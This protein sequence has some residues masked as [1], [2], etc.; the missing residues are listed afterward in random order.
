VAGKPGETL[1]TVSI[2][3]GQSM[4]LLAADTKGEEGSLA[5]TGDRIAFVSQNR[6]H[7]M[8]ADGSEVK[9]LTPDMN[10]VLGV[11]TSRYEEHNPVWTHDGKRVV[12]ISNAPGNYEVLSVS[13]DGGDVQRLT[14]DA[15]VDRNVA[16]SPDLPRIA[17]ERMVSATDSDLVLALPDGSQQLQFK[18]QLPGSLVTYGE[19]KPKFLPGGT[20]LAYVRRSA[21]RDGESL[22]IM[23]VNQGATLRELVKPLK[24]NEILYAVSP[25]GNRIAYH[26][27]AE[28][29]KKSS[30]IVIINLEGTVLKTLSLGEGVEI[31]DLAWGA[32]PL[33][34]QEAK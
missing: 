9:R 2:G 34:N 20:Q 12:F 25:D 28:W 15:R 11:R 17:F 5:P 4:Q 6:I 21:G 3:S 19:R 7:I 14:D 27:R 33:R 13:A 8:A 22:A 18:S 31:R 29:G 23:D 32:F 16:S 1:M 26:Q 30:S 24:D 10:G